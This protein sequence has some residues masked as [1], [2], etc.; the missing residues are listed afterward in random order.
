MGESFTPQKDYGIDSTR[1]RKKDEPFPPLCA[2]YFTFYSSSGHLMYFMV[3]IFG[4]MHINDEI[5][6]EIR[7]F[8]LHL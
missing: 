5:R 3:V 4:C 8:I 7:Y 2:C 6:A 1:I